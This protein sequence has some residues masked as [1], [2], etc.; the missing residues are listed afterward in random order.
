MFTSWIRNGAKKKACV[1]YIWCSMMKNL[2]WLLGFIRWKVGDG[3][4]VEI[5]LDAIKGIYG[6][7][8]L[9]VILL[10]YIHVEGTHLL[11]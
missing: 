2:Q 1:S 10:N 8:S 9:S 5:G 3:A 11:H 7:Y 4:M 6:N